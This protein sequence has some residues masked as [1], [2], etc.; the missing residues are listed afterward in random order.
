MTDAITKMCEVVKN[1]GVEADAAL[2]FLCGGL[3][4]EAALN[5]A[6]DEMYARIQHRGVATEQTREFIAWCLSSAP[7]SPSEYFVCTAKAW[8]KAHGYS[9]RGGVIVVF[10]G[11]VQGWVNELRDPGHWQPGAIAVDASGKSWTAVGGDAQS[12]AIAWEP[13]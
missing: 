6:I 13:N 2:D 8:R 7:S 11:I 5:L 1:G 3:L 10:D 4:K 9:D 12:G